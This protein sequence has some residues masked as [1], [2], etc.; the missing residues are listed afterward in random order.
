MVCSNFSN[1][2]L[3]LLLKNLNYKE[4]GKFRKERTR[5]STTGNKDSKGTPVR[6]ISFSEKMMKFMRELS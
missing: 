3:N 5:L 1:S 4:K 2:F 6:T